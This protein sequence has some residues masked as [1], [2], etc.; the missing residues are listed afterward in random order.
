MKRLDLNRRQ[1]L[2]AAGLTAAATCT[3][4]LIAEEK[5]ACGT[6]TP[7]ITGTIESIRVYTSRIV[8]R[9][10]DSGT[11]KNAWLITPGHS[12]TQPHFT[13]PWDTVHQAY[14]TDKKIACVVA[15]N[16]ADSD[17]E[18]LVTAVSLLSGGF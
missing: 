9:I 12:H 11:S 14:K 5:R 10:D 7:S 16:P 4:T 6:S 3:S 1:L 17:S 18:T 8:I 2:V 15:T 13:D